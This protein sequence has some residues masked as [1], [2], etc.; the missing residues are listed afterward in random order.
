MGPPAQATFVL[1][2]V[3]VRV[4]TTTLLEHMR[5][6]SEISK[7][8]DVPLP[9]NGERDAQGQ[10]QNPPGVLRG[11]LPIFER[12]RMYSP[13]SVTYF[14]IRSASKCNGI[15]NG[16]ETRPCEIHFFPSLS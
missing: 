5:K 11:V 14:F 2:G 6:L 3:S 12:T 4:G 15:G 16:P 8:T 10:E 9:T 13:S 1:Y 7:T